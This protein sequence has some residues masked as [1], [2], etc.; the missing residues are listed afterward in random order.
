MA[1]L[2]FSGFEAHRN[3]SFLTKPLDSLD[4]FVTFHEVAYTLVRVRGQVKSLVKMLFALELLRL[5]PR[6]AK[7]A[8]LA[9]AQRS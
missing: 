9:F 1:S 4:E 2:A 3:V 8:C 6:D 5:D 7:Y